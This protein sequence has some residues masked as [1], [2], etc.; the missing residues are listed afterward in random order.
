MLLPCD[1]GRQVFPSTIPSMIAW[2]CFNLRRGCPF[3]WYECFPIQRP[4]FLSGTTQTQVLNLKLNIDKNVPIGTARTP[5]LTF[6]YSPVCDQEQCLRLLI[7]RFFCST[8][9]SRQQIKIEN[10]LS[11]CVKLSVTRTVIAAHLRC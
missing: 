8:V 11:V 9:N 5:S 1:S 7:S 10:W 6:A 3:H 4:A 2:I